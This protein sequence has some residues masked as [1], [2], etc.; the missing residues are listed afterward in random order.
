M[1]K[2]IQEKTGVAPEKQRLIYKA[3]L[4]KDELPLSDYSNILYFIII[5]VVKEEGETIH[6]VKRPDDAVNP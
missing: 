5:N 1:R 4:L 6:M 3:K 2:I